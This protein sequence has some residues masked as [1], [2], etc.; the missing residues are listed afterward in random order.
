[1]PTL[2]EAVNN[3]PVSA[4][5]VKKN[6]IPVD[7]SNPMGPLTCFMLNPSGV[8]FESQEPTEKVVLFLRQHFIVNVPWIITAALILLAPTVIFPLLVSF[9]HVGI[10]VPANYLL[11][12][13]LAWYL[14]SFGFVLAK[15]IGWYF[16][17]FIVTNE[18]VID[19]D[20]YYLLYKHFA[21]A[22]LTKIQDIAYASGGIFAAIFNYGDVTIETAGESPNIEF[23]KVPFPER[24]V[25]TIRNLTEES[26][27]AP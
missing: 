20:I 22:E 6:V 12:G 5:P 7:G 14:A 2:F 8:R 13:T 18:R 11:I 3:K 21:Q 17:I 10:S 16:N 4:K 15:F 24:V 19:I 25:E 26:E 27:Q 9:L 23:E 1:M